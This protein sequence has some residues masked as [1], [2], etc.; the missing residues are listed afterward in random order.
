MGVSSGLFVRIV[1]AGARDRTKILVGD[2]GSACWGP[3]YTEPEPSDDAF[4]GGGS[5]G[6]STWKV[7]YSDGPLVMLRNPS[8]GRIENPPRAQEARPVRAAV[9]GG[10]MGSQLH[11]MP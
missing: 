6:G 4:L 2:P 3:R 8:T 7:A 10:A 11:I 1:G 9:A 5:G